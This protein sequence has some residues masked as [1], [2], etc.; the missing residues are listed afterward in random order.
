MTDGPPTAPHSGSGF[1]SGQAL[2]DATPEEKLR[3]P[4]PPRVGM[5]FILAFVLLTVVVFLAKQKT[6]ERALAERQKARTAT[7]VR[8]RRAVPRFSRFTSADVVTMASAISRAGAASHASAVVGQVATQALD[9]GAIVMERSIL[10]LPGEWWVLSVPVAVGLTLTAGDSVALLGGANAD[11]LVVAHDVVVLGTESGRVVVAM[12]PECARSTA[13][14]LGKEPRIVAVRRVMPVPPLPRSNARRLRP[15]AAGQQPLTGSAA[16]V[17]GQP[18]TTTGC[19][20]AS[21]R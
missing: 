9:S 17:A 11:S 19:A 8:T 13:R 4:R 12:R 16:Q 20:A 2:E 7:F 6:T 18:T 10:P 5:W 14:Y 3:Y 21:T 1:V 15:L